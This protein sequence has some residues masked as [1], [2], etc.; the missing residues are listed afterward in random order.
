MSELPYESLHKI[1]ESNCLRACNHLLFS[2]YRVAARVAQTFT[3]RPNPYL[4]VFFP[5]DMA[6]YR[7]A[8]LVTVFFSALLQ[9]CK[10]EPTG[11]ARSQ[12]HAQAS[13]AAEL[14]SQ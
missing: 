1:N 6:R 10:E 4:L 2:A 3:F 8:I 13:A 7:G 12:G 11:A 5:L 14:F 9:G